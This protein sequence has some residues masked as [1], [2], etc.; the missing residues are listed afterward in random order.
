MPSTLTQSPFRAVSAKQSIFGG[1]MLDSHRIAAAAMLAFAVFIALPSRADAADTAAPSV[2]EVGARYGQAL[3]ALE[4]CYGSKLTDKGKALEAS[5]TGADQDKFK[6]QAAKIFD[7][8]QKIKGC[9]NQR[10]PNQCKIIMD[11]SCLAAE[12]EIGQTGTAMPGLVEFLK[13]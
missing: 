4:V 7:M 8:W 9:T 13:H 1:S 3:G 12:N 11:K 6:A 2:L 10:D 5:F